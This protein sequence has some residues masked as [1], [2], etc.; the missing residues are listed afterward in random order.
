[1]ST[2]GSMEE[3]IRRIVPN[4]PQLIFTSHIDGVFDSRDIAREIKEINPLAL[5]FALTNSKS[6]EP[7]DLRAL[8][9]VFSKDTAGR[10]RVNVFTGKFLAGESRANLLELFKRI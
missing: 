2:I 1:M 10:E 9:G 5:V 3:V 8:D 6:P 4:S 7:Q